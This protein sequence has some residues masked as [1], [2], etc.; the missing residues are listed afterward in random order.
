MEA[1]EAE[2][3]EGRRGDPA[4]QGKTPAMARAVAA[5]EAGRRNGVEV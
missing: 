4:A 3:E 2:A 5:V 1:A